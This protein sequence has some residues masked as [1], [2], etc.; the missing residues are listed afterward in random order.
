MK[1]DKESETAVETLPIP[2]IMVPYARLQAEKFAR[3]K[4]VD[5][6][7]LEVIK[8]TEKIYADF[9][10]KEKTAELKAFLAGTGPAP[11]MED[12]LFFDDDRALYF[13]DTC[14]TKYGENSR[15]VREA[16]KDM[17]RAVKAVMEEENLTEIM[18]GLATQALHG[19]F[20]FNLGM[21]GCPN[22]CV[23]PY[24]KDFGI[25]MQHRVDITEAECIHCGEC[26]KMCMEKAIELADNGPFI[27]RETC[28]KCELCARDCPTGTLVT[29]QRAFRVIAGGGGGHHPAIATVIEDFTTRERVLEILRNVINR[30]RKCRPGESLRAIIRQEGPGAI[31]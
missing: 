25:I 19:A 11:A 27:N 1:W 24:M 31:C 9:M 18:A 28:V 12:E 3:Q 15:D 23:S 5:C 29:G 8:E 2:P 20:R 22:C 30:L 14:Y 4:G 7:N 26:L 6:V 13:I 10:G 16:L 17:M 21:T